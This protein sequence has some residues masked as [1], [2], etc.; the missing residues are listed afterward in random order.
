MTRPAITA[1]PLPAGS[2]L[3]RYRDMGAFTDCYAADVAGAVDLPAYVTAFYNSA[4]FRPERWL[5][6][7]AAKRPA[8]AADVARLAAGASER[9]SA[10]TV[11][12]RTPD[13][14]ML[15][16]FQGRTRSWLMVRPLATGTR[17]HFGSAVVPAER[18]GD[19]FVFNALL[20]FHRLYSRILLKSAAKRL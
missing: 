14:L 5:L 7:W 4:A 11:E 20:G 12:A 19:A 18:R 1:L 15:C 13:Q 8:T 9:F 2:L 10:W 17:L 16:D 3:E 6:G